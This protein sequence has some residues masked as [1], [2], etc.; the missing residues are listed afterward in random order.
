M[1]MTK[2]VE[3]DPEKDLADV[4]NRETYPGETLVIERNG[5]PDARP[6]SHD[7]FSG[8]TLE[9]L[10]TAVG[11]LFPIGDGFADG[12]E[13]AQADQGMAEFPEWPS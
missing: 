7:S 10:I 6:S 4:L 13:A 9:E 5:E 2:P 11:D 12:L 1:D 3:S 8:A